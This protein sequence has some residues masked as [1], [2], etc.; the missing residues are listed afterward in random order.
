MRRIIL[1][2]AFIGLTA[3]AAAQPPQ[4]PDEG[5]GIELPE[6]SANLDF[7]I[8]NRTRRTITAVTITPSGENSPWSDNVLVQRDVP[9]GERGAVSYT[10]D[11]ELCR[12]DVRVTFDNRSQQ[13]R[14]LIDLCGTM[15]VE[16][17]SEQP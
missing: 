8:V 13:T 5:Y 1:A 16:I 2:L 3:P 14:P 6:G 10:R 12:W 7:I 9:P 11:I 4:A 15:R 17:R